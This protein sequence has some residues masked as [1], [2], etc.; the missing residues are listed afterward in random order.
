MKTEAE[1]QKPFTF[2]SRVKVKKRNGCRN[3]LLS[4]F[5]CHFWV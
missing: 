5:N 1:K 2:A 4:L 3:H